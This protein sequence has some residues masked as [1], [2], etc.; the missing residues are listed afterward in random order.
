LIVIIFFDINYD[1][2]QKC[3]SHIQII[4]QEKT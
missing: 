2:N 1:M 4:A 3:V